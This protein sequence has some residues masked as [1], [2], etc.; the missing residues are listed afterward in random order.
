MSNLG[1]KNKTEIGMVGEY[2]ALDTIQN[3][4]LTGIQGKVRQGWARLDEWKRHTKLS[5]C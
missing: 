4:W 1:I 5:N 3:K 2:V